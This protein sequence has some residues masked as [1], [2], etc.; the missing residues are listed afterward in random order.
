MSRM[1]NVRIGH[2]WLRT[3]LITGLLALVVG[4]GFHL[5]GATNIPPALS[6]IAVVCENADRVLCNSVKDLL[7]RNNVPLTEQQGEGYRLVLKDSE[8]SQRATALT[9]T[10]S[11]AEYALTIS[12]E[13]ALFTPDNVPLRPGDRLSTS[14]TY[15]Y[16]ENNVLAKNRERRDLSD[17]LNEQLAQQ[18][19]YALSPY[20]R[21]RIEAIRA[22][23]EAAQGQDKPAET[24]PNPES[25]DA[26]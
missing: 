18:V 11:A 10:A 23:Y 3:G 21:N 19:L 24:A 16:D 12:V 5:R 2:R 13:M 7:A 1:M 25:D 15:R 6:P 14:Q 26:R 8:S 17:T 22:E 4:C 9:D 20:N